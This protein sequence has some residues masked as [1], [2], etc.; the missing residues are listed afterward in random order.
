[1]VAEGGRRPS[2]LKSVLLTEGWRFSFF[3]AVRLLQL[4]APDCTP[5]GSGDNAVAEAV[6]FSSHVTLSFPPS[7]VH[8]IK[9]PVAE[10]DTTGMVVNFMGLASPMSYGS[11]PTPYTELI[12]SLERDKTRSLAEFLDLFNHRLISLFYRAWEKYHYAIVYERSGQA[13]RGLIEKILFSVMGLGTDGLLKPLAING[14]AL[15][16]RAHA[17]GGRGVSALGLGGLVQDYF[18]VPARVVQFIPAWYEIEDSEVCRLGLQ[19]C[20][21]GEDMCLGSRTRM[22]QSRFR[23]RLGPL[24]WGQ[25]AG[26]LPNGDAFESL[27]EICTLVAGP[28]FDFEFQL[29]LA[30]GCTPPL[31]LGTASEHGAPRLGWST[32]LRRSNGDDQSADVI[33]NGERSAA[34]IHLS[35]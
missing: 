8:E 23:V 32:W 11:L 18:R 29:Q 31:R 24:S 21:L 10:S 4:M 26:F 13:Q 1:M 35:A 34:D 33:I 7:D 19:S 25:A 17:V 12:M 22:A 14:R 2:D 16:G 30:T 28:E 9:P 6:R 20:N 3:Q 5:V 27:S 15:L